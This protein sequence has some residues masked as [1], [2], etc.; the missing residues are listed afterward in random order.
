MKSP[1]YILKRLKKKFEVTNKY[2]SQGFPD[3]NYKVGNTSGL[4][5]AP[6]VPSPLNERLGSLAQRGGGV[7][8]LIIKSPATF[9]VDK[10]RLFDTIN[11]LEIDVSFHSEPSIG[12]TS[13]YRGNYEPTHNY[14]TRYLEQFAIFKRDA[15]KRAEEDEKFKLGNGLAISRINPH[16]STSPL[17]ALEEER[18]GDTGLDPFGFSLTDLKEDMMEEKDIE[19]KNIYRNQE[20]LRRLYQVFLSDDV[21]GDREYQYY[22]NF[23]SFSPKFDKK[24]RKLQNQTANHYY[25]TATGA[26]NTKLE[27]KADVISAVANTDPAITKEWLDILDDY[28][29]EEIKVPDEL[30]GGPIPETINNLEDLDDFIRIVLSQRYRLSELQTLS[31]LLYFL[32]N[33]ELNRVRSLQFQSEDV[34]IPLEL[35][36]DI[37]NRIKS[38][39][40]EEGTLEQALDELWMAKADEED[41]RKISLIP[42]EAKVGGLTSQLEI[43]QNKIQEET[44]QNHKDELNSQVEK[45]FSDKSM[46][47]HK[48]DQINAE[49]QYERFLRLFINNF[50]RAMWMESNIMYK[51]IPAWMAVADKKIET[52]EKGTV[53]K[54][55][56]GPKF[57]WDTL[58]KRKWA[59][60]EGYNID[61]TAP[62]GGDKGEI[63]FLDLL[64]DNKEFQEDVAAASAACYVWGHFTQK[65]GQFKVTR[66][67]HMDDITGGEGR[68]TWMEWMNKYGIGVNLE[69][70]PGSPQQQF[71]IWRPRH[72]VAACRAIN[73]TA[74]RELEDIHQD[75]DG[76][77]AKFTIDLEH[78]ATFGV[79]PWKTME[80]L[81]DQEKDLAENHLAS[82][83]KLNI[84][85]EKPL[86]KVLRM[87]HLMRPGLET[88]QSE[89]L[90]GPWDHG[91]EQLYKWLYRMVEAGFARNPEEPGY[92]MYEVGGDDRGTVYMAKIAMNMVELGITPDELDP[93]IV[94]PGE[95]Y[96]NEK[97]ALIARFYG[98]DKTSYDREWAKIEEHAFDP[99]QGLLEAEQFDY[100]YSSSAA[101]QNEN[102]PGEWQSE[103]YQ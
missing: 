61:L 35:Q 73:I 19:G 96:K 94:D 77:I 5:V 12:Y 46:F 18:P 60:K 9:Q 69:A 39:E 103:E 48:D 102:R 13:A 32:Q 33:K 21:F 68:V 57:L 23:T 41:E 25:R 28:N 70:M 22:Q 7:M 30:S 52:E 42:V 63:G 31:N 8:E 6:N 101:L 82:D 91:D 65:E 43:P 38:L 66:E 16:I 24:W 15:E 97:E 84:E 4:D 99:L 53:H 34:E 74:R 26:Y 51:I 72:I 75:L 17:P 40:D 83:Y 55:W 27:D 95:D 86:A 11:S 59:E 62:R 81:I 45:L 90:H 49:E 3:M 100:T 80:N 88:T 47:E 20:F 58:V 29:F 1:K 2:K 64:E 44:F 93:S 71:K 14:F 50:E 87:W 56:R 92:V 54:G 85:A 36:E 37:W 79:D 67:S 78:T 10:E 76:M 89:T 98:M